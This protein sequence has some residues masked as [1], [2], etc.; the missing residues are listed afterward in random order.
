MTAIPLIGDQRGEGAA[1]RVVDRRGHGGCTQDVRRAVRPGAQITG[2]AAQYQR[3][4][5]AVRA[6]H[7]DRGGAAHRTGHPVRRARGG[8]V[9]AVPGMRGGCRQFAFQGGV[10]V[11]AVITFRI[12]D[13]C[14]VMSA[15]ARPRP[16]IL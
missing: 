10:F 11:S 16:T 7:V 3:A 14:P 9:N 4:V 6:E 8:L 2:V 15:D 13:C 1:A 12:D 5:D